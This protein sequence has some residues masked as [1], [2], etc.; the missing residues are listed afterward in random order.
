MFLAH[1]NLGQALREKKDAKA[2]IEHFHKALELE[3]RFA[4]ARLNLG[5][6]LRDKK[7]L[8]SAADSFRKAIDADPKFAKP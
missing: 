6:A 4:A 7:D 1:N 2:A 8:K 3:P 5:V